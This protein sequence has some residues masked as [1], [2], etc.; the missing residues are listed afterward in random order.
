M[1]DD[2]LVRPR[3]IILQVQPSMT[4]KEILSEGA[5]GEFSPR[6]AKYHAEHS[7]ALRLTSGSAVG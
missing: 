2:K 6:F 7:L 5:G 1:I 4:L 3:D